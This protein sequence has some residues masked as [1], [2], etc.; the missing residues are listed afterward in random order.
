MILNTEI[1]KRN[2]HKVCAAMKQMC[3]YSFAELQKFT[4]LDNTALCLALLQ[5]VREGRIA[6]MK[7][8]TG[9]YYML[10]TA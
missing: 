3:H 8:E 5:L 10:C 1:I 7:D 2:S 4:L 6:Q 9:V